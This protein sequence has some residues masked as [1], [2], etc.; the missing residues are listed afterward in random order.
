MKDFIEKTQLM[1]KVDAPLNVCPD[2]VIDN[3]V[4]L[5]CNLQ[6]LVQLGFNYEQIDILL[7][8]LLDSDKQFKNNVVST[9]LSRK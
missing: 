4:E 6:Q 3:V 7:S 5:A 8:M 9:I 1:N 2:L